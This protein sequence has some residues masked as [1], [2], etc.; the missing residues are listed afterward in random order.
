MGPIY[1]VDDQKHKRDVRQHPT[2]TAARAA[3]STSP[4]DVASPPWSSLQH[5]VQTQIHI[6]PQKPRSLLVAHAVVVK[7]LPLLQRVHSEPS[8]VAAADAGREGGVLHSVA[9]GLS[10]L[11]QFSSLRLGLCTASPRRP[12]FS[13]GQET[14]TREIGSTQF[15]VYCNCRFRGISERFCCGAAE[16][17]CRSSV[18]REIQSLT[19]VSYHG[20]GLPPPCRS[21]CP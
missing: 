20:G 15:L 6:L 13:P 4:N 1:Y 11:L 3:V 8:T 16:K 21:L 5:S 9:A 19:S 10:D 7:I 12:R 18:S 17:S 14:P 2:I